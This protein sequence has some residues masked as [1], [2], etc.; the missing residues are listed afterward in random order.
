MLAKTL[1]DDQALAIDNL[2]EGLKRGQTRIVLQGPTGSGKTVIMADIVNRARLKDRKVV[3]TVP[4]ISLIDQTVVAFAAQGIL[5]VGVIQAKHSMTDWSK[6]VQIASVQTL[7]R[8]WK[9]YKEGKGEMPEA[10]VVLV[11]EVHRMFNMFSEWLV[12]P[13]WLKVPFIGF[14]ATPWTKGL[15]KLYEG[16][17]VVASTIRD[18]IARKVLVPF[19]TFAPDSP[20]LTGVRSQTDTTGVSDFVAADLDEIMRPKHLVANIVET[21]KKLAA[22]RPTVCFCCSRAH[23][24]QM[25]KEFEAAG[26]GAAYMDCETSLSERAEMRRALQRGEVKVICNCDVIGIGVDIPELSCVIYARP[27]KSDIRFVQNIGRGLRSC[28]GKTDLLILDH[29]TTTQRLGFVDE[30]PDYHGELD[31]GRPKPPA[32]QGVLLPKECPACHLL[33]PPRVATCPHCGHKVEAHAEPVEVERGT[34]REFKSGDEFTDIIKKLPDREH[35]F[36][37]LVWW[38]RDKGYNQW[39]PNM[40]FKDIY[41][42]AFPRKLN[43]EDKVSAP[44]PELVEFIYLSTKKWKE[45]QAAIRRAAARQ[46]SRANGHAKPEPKGALTEWEQALLDRAAQKHKR[47]DETLMMEDDW[48]DFR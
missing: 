6:P 5:E 48:E 43:W 32:T 28:E 46:A 14:S 30:I 1:R 26:I 11:D 27:T 25:A 24:D 17:L 34:L 3:I 31:D 29:S 22:G 35:V 13:D 42:V 40:K 9:D 44:G 2:R 47:V 15:G 38:G 16:G 37:Q 23:A 41:G 33:K 7:E 20:D 19:R 18:L 4:A 36:G 8:R 12:H 10:D 45:E 39:W 21:W